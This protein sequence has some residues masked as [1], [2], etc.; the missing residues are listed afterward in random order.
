[1]EAILVLRTQFTCFTGTQSTDTDAAGAARPTG[2]KVQILTQQTMLG[3]LQ[4]LRDP[5][6]LRPLRGSLAP[7]AAPVPADEVLYEE[8][9]GSDVTL[10]I[11]VVRT[12]VKLSVIC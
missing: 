4:D 9:E 8:E 2:H 12:S 7:A 3:A 1:M 10:S 5:D 6:K 11:K